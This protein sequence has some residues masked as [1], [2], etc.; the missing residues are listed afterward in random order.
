MPNYH[1][2]P[3]ISLNAGSHYFHSWELPEIIHLHD[4]ALEA[5]VD[6]TQTRA[7]TISQDAPIPEA[8]LEMSVCGV[9]MLIA[10]DEEGRVMGLISSEDILGSKP[11][12]IIQERKVARDKIKVRMI[13]TPSAK[14]TTLDIKELQI[15]KVGHVIETMR[16]A[17]QHYA[18]VVEIDAENNT[19]TVVGLY[20]LSTISKQLD[21]NVTDDDLMA[22]SLAEL[23]GKI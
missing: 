6:L 3:T 1:T 12:Q 8:R 23:E 17:R 10:T 22:R 19:Q 7:F 13:M 4:S 5:M 2:L 9:H 14:I 20:S 18:F 11:L 16:A 15:A 21:M